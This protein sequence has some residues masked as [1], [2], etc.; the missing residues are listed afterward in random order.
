MASN[1][2]LVN[3][4]GFAGEPDGWSFVT[5]RAELAPGHS[6]KD[7]PAGRRLVLS[8]TGDKH[9]FGCWRGEMTLEQGNWY[10]A[11]VR[12]RTKAVEHPALS[13]FAQVASHFLVPADAWSE[14]TVLEQTFHYKGDELS[15]YFEAHIRA[16]ETGEIEYFDPC[17][18]KIPR[19]EP[20]MVRVAT[21]RFGDPTEPLTLEGQRARM[22]RKLDEAGGL[23]ADIVCLTEWCPVAGVEKEV[24]GSIEEVAEEVPSGPTCRLLS[25]KAKEYGMYVIC[26]ILERL[27]KH[28]FNS[29]V[30]FDRKGEY[31]GA[32]HKTHPMF[33][34]LELG[35]SC[36]DSYPVF[37]LDFGRI[38][39]HICYDEWFPEVSRY[40]AH[41]GAEILFLPVAGGKPITWR[42]RALDNAIYFV[43]SSVNPP[44]RIIDSSGEIIAET[45]SD[46]IAY[47][48]LDL[49]YRKVNWYVDPTLSYSMPCIIPQMRTV[50]DHKLIDDLHKLLREARR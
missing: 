8:A 13:V 27:G 12:V 32:Y 14:E 38:A 46:G 2:N 21:V 24:Y 42:T 16:A 36:G 19:P 25:A 22:G 35:I 9:A 10:R 41:A 3:N 28:I 34:E 47:A 11:T 43:S 26:G 15:K 45:H 1:G 18:V 17:V 39:L 49:N 5:P 33:A 30:I 37:D 40:Y 44:S 23:N 48:D 7:T 20:R 6:V 4:P 31:V 29:A 50:V